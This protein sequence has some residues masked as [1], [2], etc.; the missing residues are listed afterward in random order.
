AL[1]GF[2]GDE[3][4]EMAYLGLAD[5]VDAAEALLNPVGIPWQVI[6]HHQVR[7]LKVNA[8]ARSIRGNE[9]L[10]LR[11]MLEGFLRLHAFLATHAAVDD[12]HRVLA[13]EQR[14]DTGFEVAQRVAMLGEDNQ[15]L[16]RRR[17]RRR[18]CAGASGGSL[19]GRVV[20]YGG[21]LENLAEQAGDLAQLKVLATAAHGVRERFKATEGS[22]F[23]FE[24]VDG[25]RGRR[26][27]ENLL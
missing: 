22:D 20:E 12:N 7:A 18:N 11:V 25:A 14:S 9:H 5:A 2:L 23:G 1:A 26:L 10:Y 13:P 21:R 15:L 4:P 3:V 24:L 27:I 8:L 19:A 6:I 16:L 17:V